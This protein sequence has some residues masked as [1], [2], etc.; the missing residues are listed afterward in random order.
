MASEAGAEGTAPEAGAEGI[1]TEAE[2]EA[3]A[4]DAAA[5]DA[6]S[7]AGADGAALEAGA[8]G[9]A[10]DGAAGDP[11]LD[12]AAKGVV[13]K[14]AREEEAARGSVGGVDELAGRVELI[15]PAPAPVAGGT[16]GAEFPGVTEPPAATTLATRASILAFS[17]ASVGGARRAICAIRRWLVFIRRCNSIWG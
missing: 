11:A 10:L 17:W 12:P 3:A 9:A 4:L 15:A 5:E 2:A 14:A 13:P 8:E 7:D 6:A 1:A 16:A